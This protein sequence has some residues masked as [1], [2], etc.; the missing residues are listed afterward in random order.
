MPG[1]E[2]HAQDTPGS[3]VE[4]AQQLAVVPRPFQA[5]LD[6]SDTCKQ[7][8]DG[9]GFTACR[10]G[11]HGLMEEVELLGYMRH[12]GAPVMPVSAQSY[13]M[14]NVGRL[15]RHYNSSW[16]ARIS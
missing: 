8:S 5:Q 7:A 4:L 11:A 12:G 1:T 6:P 3:V 9:E 15:E 13:S 2:P 10:G 14:E 16:S